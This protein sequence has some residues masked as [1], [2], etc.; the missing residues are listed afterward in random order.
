MLEGVAR[1][2]IAGGQLMLTNDIENYPGFPQKIAGPELMGQF[3]GQSVAQGVEIVAE[4]VERVDLSARPFR[5]HIADSAAFYAARALIIA[6][7]AQAKWLELESERKLRGRGVSACAVCDGAFF[8]GE[9]VI[10]VGGGD[11]AME[12]ATYLA[13]LCRSV[14]LVHRREEFRAS[15]AMQERVRRHPKIRI[16][17]NTIVEEILDVG[18]ECVTGARLYDR[19]ANASHTVSAAGFFVAIGHTPNS[20]LVRGQL[21]LHDNGYIR[22]VAGSSRTSVEGVFACGDVQDFTYRQAITAA[23]SGCIA[24]LDAERWLA[25]SS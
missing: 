24:A 10:V 6:T 8:R 13:C 20:D 23:G 21:E 3:R 11:T 7:G 17:T 5:V 12:E 9:D 2:G 25:Q 1:G 16:L 15:R 18:A 22:T 4:D 14:T 19:T